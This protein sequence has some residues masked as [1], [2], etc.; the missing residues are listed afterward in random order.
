VVSALARLPI[1]ILVAVV[2]LS[3]CDG[4]DTEPDRITSDASRLVLQPPDV[5]EG[6][7]RFDAG[8]AEGEGRPLGSATGPRPRSAW[9]ARYRQVDPSTVK[10]PLVVESTAAVFPSDGA[11]RAAL[12][13]R[14]R[15]L[16]GIASSESV[17]LS[18]IGEEALG[19]TYGQ[20]AIPRDVRFFV[21]VWLH[22][23]VMASLTVQGFEGKVTM[24]DAVELA[25]AQHRHIGEANR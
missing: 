7:A 25:R 11:A 22:R 4:P 6:L 3:G 24:G 12:K 13:R 18:P 5:P 21:V 1:G 19:V 9:I 2:T 16:E 17:T 10:G 8:P 14:S 20:P 15:D 23:N